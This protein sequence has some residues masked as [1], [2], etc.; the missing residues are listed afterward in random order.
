MEPTPCPTSRIQD[1][2]DVSW[3]KSG[4][5]ASLMSL[6]VKGVERQGEGG[7]Y[8]ASFLGD[9]LVGELPG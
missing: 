7:S 6:V 2:Q 9:L 1:F 4:G 3:S 8:D 5:I